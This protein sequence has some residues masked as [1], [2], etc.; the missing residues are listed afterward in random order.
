M[1]NNTDENKDENYDSSDGDSNDN[2]RTP[3]LASL[4]PQLK[5]R[6]V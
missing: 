2:M 1:N 5:G 3:P 4:L 6:Y